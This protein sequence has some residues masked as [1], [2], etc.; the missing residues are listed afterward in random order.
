[1]WTIDN[2]HLADDIGVQQFK[3][4][5]KDNLHEQDVRQSQGLMLPI[6]SL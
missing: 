4:V 2:L 6:Q 3:A 5:Y 1:M